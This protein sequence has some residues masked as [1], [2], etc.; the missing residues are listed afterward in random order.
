MSTWKLKSDL[1]LSK[2]P[3]LRKTKSNQ[4][5]K[6][7]TFLVRRSDRLA[8]LNFVSQKESSPKSTRYLSEQ[9]ISQ[10]LVCDPN[11]VYSRSLSECDISTANASAFYSF[12]KSVH[13]CDS[14]I[15]SEERKSQHSSQKSINSELSKLDETLTSNPSWS[16][17]PL[18]EDQQFQHKQNLNCIEPILKFTSMTTLSDEQFQQLLN[19]LCKSQVS[20]NISGSSG[21]EI[22]ARSSG[23]FEFC[24]QR[25]S[26]KSEYVDSF[27]NAIKIY[28]TST[29]MTNENA[30][31]GFPLLLEGEAS[32]WWDG[33]KSSVN[34]FEEA[35]ALLISTF[36]ICKPPHIIYQEIFSLKQKDNER[37]D[38]FICKVRSLF[39][40]L[41]TGEL[42]EKIQL[43]MSY[44]LISLKIRCKIKREDF[45]TF[46]E[47]LKL[48]RSEE[49]MFNE[50]K[51][52]A[53]KPNQNLKMDDAIE[54]KLKYFCRYCKSKEHNIAECPKKAKNDQLSK[55]KN[56]SNKLNSARD[57]EPK[58]RNEISCYGCQKKGF[59]KSNCPDCNVSIKTSSVD[60]DE[61][62]SDD[63]AHFSSFVT[64][65]SACKPRPLMSIKIL[66]VNGTH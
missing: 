47:L 50:L 2:T 30:L 6:T 11:P 14:S 58:V 57:L 40:K 49:L 39:S 15:Q 1:L 3:D 29:L 12:E 36:S 18:K 63:N 65:D 61:S 45:Q 31:L 41:P 13:Y 17:T 23:N 19:R 37:T 32:L 16:S 60:F 53:P 5:N 22:A 51:L 27:V 10:S 62:T 25:F 52:H 48:T 46:E 28:K 9:Q 24:S 64:V 7:S 34:S 56:D 66:G 21:H 42:N 54:H 38:L 4:S 35:V 59:I 44:G 43:D 26:G 33:V 55:N 8:A 20:E